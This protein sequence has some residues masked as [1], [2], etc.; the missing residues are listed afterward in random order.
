MN[1]EQE[2][3]KPN[4]EPATMAGFYPPKLIIERLSAAPVKQPIAALAAVNQHQNELTEVFLAAMERGVA[5]PE[6]NFSKEGMLFN[7]AAYFLAKWRER[8]AFPLFVRWFSLPGEQALELGGDTVVHTGARFLA[9]VC[10]GEVE[11]LKALVRNGD[12]HPVCRGQALLALGVLVAWGELSAAEVENYAVTLAREALDQKPN[13]LWNDLA[14][15]CVGLEFS[16][17][18]PDLRRA[19]QEQWIDPE[20][21]R[22]ESFDAFEKEPK[23]EFVKAF[24]ARHS[25]IVDVINETRWWAGFQQAALPGAVQQAAP[26]TAGAK[27]GR[28]DPCPCGS[29]KK[30][31]KCCGATAN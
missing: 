23:G 14:A 28:N 27:V 11:P 30:Y 31:K 12:A 6:G 25:P 19:C 15:L 2:A 7:Y 29:G 17:L 1:T 18:F 10:G 5:D 16:S 24:A 9:S 4:A 3:G 26:V 13:R 20:F 22:V 8:R 21:L